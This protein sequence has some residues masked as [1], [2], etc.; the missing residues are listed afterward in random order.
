MLRVAQYRS[1]EELQPLRKC[2][3]ALLQLSTA[4]TVFLT[5]QWCEAWWK[6][7]GQGLSPYVL[8]AWEG[9]EV[10][11]IAP[12][13]IKPVRRYGQTW[14]CLRLIGD[15][16]H[17]SDY[18][19]CFAQPGRE[20]EAMKA[21]GDCLQTNTRLW[22]WIE[23][24]GPAHDSATLAAINAYAHEKKWRRHSESIPCAVLRLPSNWNE[25][26]RTLAPRFRT[27][28]RSAI[29]ALTEC[30]G[31]TPEQCTSTDQM[32]DWLPLLFELHTR[33][34]GTRSMPGVFRDPA[35][36]RF[37]ADLSRAA[38]EQGWLAFH[39]LDWGER[40]LAFQYG[41][42]YH[43]RFHLLQEGYD[44][45]FSELRPGIALRA[46]LM[47]D[48]IGTSLR[49]YDFLA[50]VSDY[51]LDWGAQAQ[52]RLKLTISARRTC[53]L[54]ATDMPRFQS[55]TREQLSQ[56][57]PQ[58]LL[59]WRRRIVTRRK[60]R[61]LSGEPEPSRP[62]KR[63]GWAR[64]L[65]SAVYSS[66]P[67]GTL[68]RTAAS[69]YFWNPGRVGS[70][71]FQRRIT[72]VCHIFQYHRVNDD[73]DPFLGATPL[74]TF[75][76]HM[77]Y[78]AT[79]FPFLT[80][81]Q[82]IRGE[83]PDRPYCVAVTFDD[84]YRDNFV[85]AFPVLKELRIPATVFL[86][87]G[88]VDSGQLPWYDQVR[89][90]F[91]LTTRSEFSIVELKGPRA[92]LRNIHDRV[93][94]AEQVLVWLRGLP[95]IAR[96]ATLEELFRVLGVPADL[97]LPNQM[98]KWEDIRQMSKNGVSFGAH[99]INHPVLSK[100]PESD[101]QQEIRGSKHTIENRLQRPV[102]H[103]AYPFGQSSD[104]NE[105]VKGIIRDAG[106]KTAATA[107]W[108]LNEPTDDP[109][110]LRRFT[111]WDAEP[112]EFGLKM[113]WYRFSKLPPTSQTREATQVPASREVA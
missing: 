84:G 55:R 46:W 10:I 53:S 63:S 28:V 5:W 51:K 44:P 111:P 79:H 40:P 93:R 69:H 59:E 102:L 73:H 29:A 97:N 92:S 31:I 113:D 43:D 61:V 105:R 57:A 67:L 27:K 38:L 17:D 13:Y 52:H 6:N 35:K 19:D 98:L 103:F 64:R 39:R 72:P 104:F 87:T 112:A 33:R 11:G 15:G 26:L 22:D 109:Y 3:N 107:M 14:R 58:A 108:G 18:L 48:W 8:A 83:F 66:S 99:T 82:L 65:A 37:Y 30:L 54:V 86:A 71:P 75:R 47:R 78:L 1:W 34:W 90:A 20:A 25:Y 88:Y 62:K 77:R 68:S 50:G 91:K 24:N 45:D 106:F 49:E 9:S 36:R 56:I 12:F 7:Y 23:L 42:V 85:C 16:S 60:G 21:F 76:A 95:E 80:L 74:A 110:E 101:L 100:I 70:F 81:D 89:L 96:Q 4:D 94:C 2:W 32:Q 41:L